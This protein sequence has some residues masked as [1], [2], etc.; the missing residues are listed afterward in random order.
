MGAWGTGQFENDSALDWVVDLARTP[1][2]A[3][4]AEALELPDGY[5]DADACCMALAAAETIAAAKGAPGADLPDEIV[6]FAKTGP[7]MTPALIAA[8]TSAVAKVLQSSEL[9]ELWKE[10]DEYDGWR[11]GLVDLQRRLGAS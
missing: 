6:A 7:K 10:S 11:A 4:V 5:L 3:K 8:A 1:T 9:E 2:V